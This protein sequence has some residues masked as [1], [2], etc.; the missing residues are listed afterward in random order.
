MRA[1][2]HARRPHCP[3]SHGA[4]GGWRCEGINLCRDGCQWIPVVT[5]IVDFVAADMGGPARALPK[6]LATFLA[7]WRGSGDA[8]TA[9]EAAVQRNGFV[10]PPRR[11]TVREARH[12]G[13]P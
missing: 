3:R 4:V 5:G 9:V 12:L 7:D 8:F 1:A 11:R 2:Q 13:Q 6:P 10:V